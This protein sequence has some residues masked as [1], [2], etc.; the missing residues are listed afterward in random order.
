MATRVGR[1]FIC[2]LFFMGMPVAKAQ[3]PSLKWQI[4]YIECGQDCI[5]TQAVDEEGNLYIYV[6]RHELPRQVRLYLIP[7]GT[8]QILEYDL[9][10]LYSNRLGVRTYFV[11]LADGKVVVFNY[12]GQFP[13][14]TLL[15]LQTQTVTPLDV[16]VQRIVECD[17]LSSL[18]FTPSIYRVGDG[19]VLFCSITGGAYYIHTAHLDS[20]AL[21]IDTSFNMGPDE[22][23]KPP[24]WRFMAGS[25]DGRIYFSPYPDNPVLKQ[26]APQYAQSDWLPDYLVLR[27]DP[28]TRCWGTIYIPTSSERWS[29]QGT[30][31]FSPLI[32]VDSAG[33]LYFWNDL[34]K[35]GG[36]STSDFVKYSPY[37]EKIWHLTEGD[38]GGRA[39][40]PLL[41]GEDEFILD[42]GGG[43]LQYVMR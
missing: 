13:P 38:F 14:L 9:S 36:I 28:V 18:K 41:V 1:L 3:S 26:V 42:F 37:G 43:N 15:S 33:N 4:P 19:R 23:P 34:T 32:G 8:S 17:R 5:R 39:F 6:Q 12:D 7:H 16:G 21:I 29:I 35:P 31:T 10:E 30:D 22:R 25:M 20:G 24:S 40:K 27:Y 11:P 2:L